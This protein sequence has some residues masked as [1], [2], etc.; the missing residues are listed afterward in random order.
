MYVA[1][2]Y[3]GL[4]VEE[5]EVNW[6]CDCSRERMERAIFSMSKKDIE[7]L[8]EDEQ[9]EVSC[10]FCNSTYV[11]SKDEIKNLINNK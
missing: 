4:E 8:A 7:E 9:T 11:F 5:R 10:H 1:K 2:E 3:L 6:N